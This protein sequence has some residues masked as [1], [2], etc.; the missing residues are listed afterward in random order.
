MSWHGSL[1]RGTVIA[2][3]R[4]LDQG[5]LSGDGLRYMELLLTIPSQLLRSTTM[6]QI[7]NG[8]SEDV[9]TNP[10]VCLRAS[11]PGGYQL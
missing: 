7:M 1:G 11:S 2:E 3:G 4:R 6:S 10:S 5:G 8:Y 9:A